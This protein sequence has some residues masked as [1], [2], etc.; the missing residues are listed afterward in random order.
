MKDKVMNLL[1]KAFIRNVIIVVSGTASAQAITILLSPI[2]TRLYGPEAY[3]VMGSFL[4]IIGIIG[5][6]AA[7][8]YP[9]AIVLPS[10]NSEARDIAKLSFNITVGIATLVTLFLLFLN[11]NIVNLFNLEDIS[12]YIYLIPIVILFEGILQIYEQWLIRTQQFKVIAKVSF[13]QSFVLN[14]TKAGFG[15]L[16]PFASVLIILTAISSGLKSLMMYLLMGKRLAFTKKLNQGEHQSLKNIAIKYKDFPLFR[17]PE[18]FLN[19]ISTSL[20]VLLLTIFF[21]PASAGLYSIG[22]TVLGLPSGLIGKSVGDVFYPR[23]S[24]AKHNGENL[25]KLI[26]KATIYLALVGILPF[27]IIIMFGPYL[28]SFVFGSDWEGA[29]HYARWIAPWFFFGFINKPSIMALPVLSA[30]NFHLKYTIFMLIIR[31]LLLSVGYFVFSSDLIAIAL[32]GI[33]GAFLNLFLI[34]L[35]LKISK[36]FDQNIV[37]GCSY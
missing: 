20:P 14:G 18:V 11:N 7:L 33:S 5:P 34:I 6:I 8:T 12:T 24:G 32:F 35:T 31:F 37:K 25:T 15:F 30:Q 16:Y 22:R 17:A 26:K 3:G 4:A 36:R 2:I 9:I 27:L 13:L 10:L 19:A 21:G 29:G 1:N 28:F 23:I